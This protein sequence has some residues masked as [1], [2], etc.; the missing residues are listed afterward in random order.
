M[1]RLA[2]LAIILF[3]CLHFLPAQPKKNAAPTKSATP[4]SAEL[5]ELEKKAAAARESDQTEEAVGL[6]K[7]LVNMNPSSAEY[8]WYLGTIY[9]ESD[10][11]LE[12][13]GAFRHVTGLKPQMALAWAMLGLCEFETK[14]YD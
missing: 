2:C 3:G 1:R 9:Y 14:N 7:Q 4:S 6:Y 12:G 11:Y 5:P 10:Q 13:Q 8:W